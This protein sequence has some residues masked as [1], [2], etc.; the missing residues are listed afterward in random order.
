MTRPAANLAAMAVH[1]FRLV[2]SR[3]ERPW[4]LRAYVPNLQRDGWES[5]NTVV[6]AL[7]PDRR[8]IVDTLVESLAGALPAGLMRMAQRRSA[9][10]S[11]LVTSLLHFV[12]SPS[13]E[14]YN[15]LIGQVMR[16]SK[17]KANPAQVN[18]LL[19]AKLQ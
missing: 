10:D 16:A 11:G 4:V 12:L 5:A 15:A 14:G 18:D 3:G 2:C 13:V 7:M 1:A 19:K 9:G 8:F 6:E 17:G